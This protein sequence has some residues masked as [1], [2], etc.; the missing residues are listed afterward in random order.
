MGHECVLACELDPILNALYKTNYGIK[1]HVDIRTLK[2]ADVNDHDILCAGFPCQ[3]FSKAGFQ[4]GLKCKTNGD[5]INFVLDIIDAKLPRYVLLENVPNLEKH[6]G[7]ATLKKILERLEAHYDVDRDKLS[8]HHFG[9]AQVRERLF[10]VGARKDVGLGMF[11]F[12]EPNGKKPSIK[13][14][15]DTKPEDAKQIPKNIIECVDVWQEFVSAFPVDEELPS[16]PIW[17][18]EFGADYPL[19]GKHPLRRT[20][21]E[22][23]RYRG[24]FGRSLEACRREDE[25]RH[26]LPH[27][28][29][30]ESEIEDGAFPEWKVQFIEQNRA[31]YAKHKK[32]ID[33][34]IEK[35]H[36]FP[37]SLQKLEWNCKGEPRNIWDYV[38]QIRASGVR[39]K[40]TTTAPSLIAMTTTQVPIIG[41]E[42]RYMTPKE[43]ARL[44][45]MDLTKR[46]PDTPTR[47]YKALGNAVNVELV[48]MIA[49]SLIEE[50]AVAGEE[51]RQLVAV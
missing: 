47:A 43:C 4:E 23:S 41:W 16:F 25:L 32:W 1:P 44:Q 24:S 3:S 19:D 48:R 34:W 17:A 50:L 36:K 29:A 20:V 45:S 18:M 27:Y 46:L 8:P 11:S 33:P 21:A 26:M 40:R 5:L 39:V 37:H 38:L 51:T 30:I 49:E 10:I 31:L 35:L 2:V 22:M 12:P 7:G 14:C 6:E 28:A 13:K 15:L 9:I 42:K